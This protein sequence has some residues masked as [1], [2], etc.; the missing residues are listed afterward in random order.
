MPQVRTQDAFALEPDLLGDALGRAV[1]RIR[2]ELDAL[3][4]ELLERVA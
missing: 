2:H 4:L 1:V 3:K